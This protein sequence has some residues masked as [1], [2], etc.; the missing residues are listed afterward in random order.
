M[1]VRCL[2]PLQ[3]GLPGMEPE[4][5]KAEHGGRLVF[6]GGAVNAQS[7]LEAGT[8]EEVR[9]EARRNAGVLGRG[10]GYVFA[11]SHNVQRDVPAENVVALFETARE[12]VGR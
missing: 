10:G 5:L 11:A 12:A 2:N 8:P 9:K 6:W 7:T 4:S 1:G 3:P